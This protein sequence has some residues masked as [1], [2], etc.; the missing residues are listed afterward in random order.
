MSH[1]VDLHVGKRLRHFRTMQGLSQEAMAKSI[2]ITFQQIQKYERGV[3]RMSASRLYE[4]SKLLHVPLEQFFEGIEEA[5]TF[6]EPAMP[7]MNFAEAS[8]SGFEHEKVSDRESLEMM[9]AF[10][11]IPSL[12]MRRRLSDFVRAIADDCFGVK[13][14]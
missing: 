8:S 5:E 6:K 7:V 4:F 13:S 11:R 9:K 2:G 14:D 1:P 12:N 3:N 10:Q